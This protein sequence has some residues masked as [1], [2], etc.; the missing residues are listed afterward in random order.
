MARKLREFIG[1][2][3]KHKPDIQ[4]GEPVYPHHNIMQQISL[5][6]FSS[7]LDLKDYSNAEKTLGDIRNCCSMLEFSICKSR[8]EKAKNNKGG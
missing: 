8:L 1:H 2:N 6:K 7:Y 3:R 4:T 5:Y